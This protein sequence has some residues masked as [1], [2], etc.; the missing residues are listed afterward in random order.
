MLGSNGSASVLG[1]AVLFLTLHARNH[2]PDLKF[3]IASA[4]RICKT[5]ANHFAA[6]PSTKNAREQQEK[7]A[8]VEAALWDVRAGTYRRIVRFMV[9]QLFKANFLF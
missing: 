7:R 2:G 1:V 8:R 6:A 4:W 3:A 9:P 5:I